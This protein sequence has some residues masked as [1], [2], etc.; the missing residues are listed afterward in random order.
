LSPCVVIVARMVGRPSIVMPRLGIA[1]TAVPGASRAAIVLQGSPV[2][3][4]FVLG[5]GSNS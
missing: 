3:S 4:G 2:P 1:Y 5:I